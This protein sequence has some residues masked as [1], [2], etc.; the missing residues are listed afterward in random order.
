MKKV[1]FLLLL[2]AALPAAR[3]TEAPAPFTQDVDAALAYAKESG[4]P[5]L[6]DF[7][8]SDWC[9]WC[10]R[11]QTEVFVKETW[12]T[13]AATSL[14]T[15][16]LDFPSD[17]TLVPEAWRPRNRMLA[18]AYGV[19]AFPTFVLLAP[20]GGEEIARPETGPATTAESFVRDVRVAL[21]EADPAALDAALGPEDA[22]TFASLKARVKQIEEEGAATAAAANAEIAEWE[23]KLEE[24]KANA[25][26]TFE[27]LRAQALSELTAKRRDRVARNRALAAEY[28]EALE[29][30]SALREKLAR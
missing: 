4:L 18:A 30:L 21:V 19:E 8:G 28:A 6:L 5:V 16:L 25:P 3:A 26:D 24:A 2:C 13:W 14:V 27:A 17:E 22:K 29:R 15:V 23:K 9:G 12:K 1:L 10:K 20:G 7:S 11:M